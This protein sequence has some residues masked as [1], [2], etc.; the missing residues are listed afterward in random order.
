[1]PT[2][3]EIP[4]NVDYT[5]PSDGQITM[6]AK[7][8]LHDPEYAI[9]NLYI[10]GRKTASWDTGGFDDLDNFDVKINLQVRESEV[11]KLE[12]DPYTI[13]VD[14]IIYTT[15]FT[16]VGMPINPRIHFQTTDA[17]LNTD[18]NYNFVIVD[19]KFLI[20]YTFDI[21]IIED[22]TLIST[23]LEQVK[24]FDFGR[25]FTRNGN[26]YTL[27]INTTYMTAGTYQ[28]IIDCEDINNN[29]KR[30]TTFNNGSTIDDYD[31]TITI[32]YVF[33][34]H[35]VIPITTN[36]K[37]LI[38]TIDLTSFVDLSSVQPG[39]NLTNY[40]IK[41]TYTD[42]RDLTDNKEF[43]DINAKKFK[44]NMLLKQLDNDI[45]WFFQIFK[46]SGE[47]VHTSDDFTL[48]NQ[49]VT[50][51]NFN[52]TLYSLANN[53]ILFKNDSQWIYMHESDSLND[54]NIYYNQ[55]VYVEPVDVE[56]VYVD[57]EYV[58]YFI[59]GSSEYNTLN[60]TGTKKIKLKVILTNKTNAS[61]TISFD[62]TEFIIHKVNNFSA[63]HTPTI[64]PISNI[65]YFKEKKFKFDVSNNKYSF[66]YGTLLYDIIFKSRTAQPFFDINDKYQN[67]ITITDLITE[68][69]D[70]EIDVLQYFFTHGEHTLRF[71]MKNELEG[72]KSIHD[73]SSVIQKI[74]SS[75]IDIDLNVESNALVSCKV[76]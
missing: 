23:N 22:I 9:V 6:D 63:F 16:F 71:Y 13:Y 21:N 27:T 73:T 59:H 2:E 25:E 11:V 46:N 7:F 12:Y 65:H 8:Y 54:T 3:I 45:S 51:S 31:V 20:F 47:I 48:V 37:D 67:N 76:Q 75:N 18:S 42:E 64:T 57:V 24:S 17:I 62:S 10:D 72:V 69:N 1:M 56:H 50:V 43:I 58:V 4:H 39:D 44:I 66:S 40:K 34:S 61:D 68:Q 55:H 38:N 35:S 14:S 41:F 70:V 29:P 26:A 33:N 28:I 5:I 19:E 74:T 49:H 30:F 60:N 53:T 15:K 32:P 52:L 36:V